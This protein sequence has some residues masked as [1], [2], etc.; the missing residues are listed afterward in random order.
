MW[1][2]S[3]K[4]H[5]ISRV[6]PL[7]LQLWAM[8]RAPEI[9]KLQCTMTQPVPNVHNV[10][11]SGRHIVGAEAILAHLFSRA[12]DQAL[13]GQNGM[14][15]CT[16]HSTRLLQASLVVRL[17]Q[18]S[19]APAS[20]YTNSVDKSLPRQ[21]HLVW[22]QQECVIAG[23]LKGLRDCHWPGLGTAEISISRSALNAC[24]V[25]S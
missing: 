7:L 15:D 16:S 11:S 3:P 9:P 23:V 2:H 8:I 5:G 14:T 24:T 17:A 4:L 6:G 22:V 10:S 12:K 25:L 18:L 13:S 1:G 20:L 21:L 19:V